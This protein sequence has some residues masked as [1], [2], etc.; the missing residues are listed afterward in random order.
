MEKLSHNDGF[1]RCNSIFGIEGVEKGIL[2]EKL[3]VH[4][5]DTGYSEEEFPGTVQAWISA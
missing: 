5:E 1:V 3:Q 4:R 2:L